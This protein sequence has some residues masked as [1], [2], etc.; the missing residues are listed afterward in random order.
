[1]TIKLR[2]HHKAAPERVI[3]SLDRTFDLTPHLRDLPPNSRVIMEFEQNAIRTDVGGTWPSLTLRIQPPPP[4]PGPW[5]KF[6]IEDFM[7]PETLRE[8]LIAIGA[9]GIGYKGRDLVQEILESMD[10]W[11]WEVED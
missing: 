1:M 5:Y 4:D 3:V 7:R 8:A 10:S 9:S 6:H 2:K 11:E